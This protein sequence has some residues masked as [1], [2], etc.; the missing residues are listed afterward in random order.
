MSFFYYHGTRVHF[1]HVVILWKT[2]LV[3]VEEVQL[4]TEIEINPLTFMGESISVQN[5]Q[6]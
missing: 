1:C 4:V 6:D 5:I 3:T 2:H